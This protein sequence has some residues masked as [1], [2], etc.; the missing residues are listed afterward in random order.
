[1]IGNQK[2][3]KSQKNKRQVNAGRDKKSSSKKWIRVNF[4][5]LNILGSKTKIPPDM[6]G[7]SSGAQFGPK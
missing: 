1:M 4:R 3:K 6:K 7:R 5:D 2:Y